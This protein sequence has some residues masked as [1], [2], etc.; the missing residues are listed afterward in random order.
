MCVCETFLTCES[1][2]PVTSLSCFTKLSSAVYWIQC[3]LSRRIS[4]FV[5]HRASL[6][7]T[8]DSI[9]KLPALPAV[10]FSFISFELNS[11]Q[12]HRKRGRVLQIATAF[13]V[14]QFANA[15]DVF[16]TGKILICLALWTDTIDRAHMHTDTKRTS[17]QRRPRIHAS[18]YRPSV[19]FA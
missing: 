9:V 11:S 4:T 8:R 16:A 17:Q 12:N 1:E 2:R 6:V 7:Q 14:A 18:V 5:D 3:D 10:P 13:A 19:S 15:T